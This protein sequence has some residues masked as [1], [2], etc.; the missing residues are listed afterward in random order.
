MCP[1]LI[2]RK[3]NVE[4]FQKIKFGDA[5]GLEHFERGVIYYGIQICK[6][7]ECFIY[8]W[9]RVKRANFEEKVSLK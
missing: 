5:L 9:Y 2:K 1:N 3:K 7:C 8:F 4:F 6:G